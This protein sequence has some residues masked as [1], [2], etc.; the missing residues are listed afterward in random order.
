MET[1]ERFMWMALDL[2]RQGQGKTSPNPMTGAVVVKDG[3]VVGTGF[4]ESAGTEHAEIIALR[5]AGEK[6]EGAVLYV[7]LEPCCHYGRTPPCVEA[8]I[9]AGVRK[10]VISTTDPNP[11]VSGKGIKRMEEAGVKVKSGVLEDKARQLNEVFFKYITSKTPFVIL[12]S[13]LTLDGKIATRTGKSRWITGGKSREFV[14]YLRSISDAVM[15]GINT[16][17]EDDPQLNVRLVDNVSHSPSRIIIDSRGKL[18]LNSKVVQT[19]PETRTILVT[20]ELAKDEDLLKLEQS[21]VEIIKLPSKDNRV[22]LELLMK[23]LGEREISLVLVESGGN[24]NYSLL[25]KGLVDK[26]YIFI[27][28]LLF[29]GKEALTGLEGLGIDDPEK[30]WRVE[31]IEIKHLEG[32]LLVKGYP[33]RREQSIVYG[34]SGR[35]GGTAES[36]SL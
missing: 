8:I 2:A 11:L 12:K 5:E 36:T 32:D 10:V 17:I 30:A 34:D 26:I 29:G 21:G 9:E 22:D 1:E 25:E 18:P 6:A 27:A 15:V 16:V 24:L 19:S 23:K 35:T 7:N 14:H 3:E 4:H 13:A 28:P 31:G 20:T 33:L